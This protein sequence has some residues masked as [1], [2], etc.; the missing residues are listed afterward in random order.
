M[1]VAD[2]RG[3]TPADL[4]AEALLELAATE[5]PAAFATAACRVD[6][7]LPL[8]NALLKVSWKHCWNSCGNNVSDFQLSSRWHAFQIPTELPPAQVASRLRL[9]DALA[10]AA[11]VVPALVARLTAPGPLAVLAVGTTIALDEVAAEIC[12][13]NMCL[14]DCR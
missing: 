9:L 13:P 8:A 12:R 14:C 11:A 10:S 6:W 4:P 2:V 5:S 7:S 3:P 1:A